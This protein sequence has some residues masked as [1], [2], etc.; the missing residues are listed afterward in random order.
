MGD[1]NSRVGLRNDCII[2]DENISFTDGADHVPDTPL[3][4]AS[5]DSVCKFRYKVVRRV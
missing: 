4:R 1:L 3:L 2:H 5:S